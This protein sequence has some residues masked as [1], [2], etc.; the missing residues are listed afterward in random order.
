MSILFW[1]GIMITVYIHTFK[2]DFTAEHIEK[3][4]TFF[5]VIGAIALIISVAFSFI[6]RGL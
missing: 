3:A 2:D 1:V 5:I 4:S 6:G